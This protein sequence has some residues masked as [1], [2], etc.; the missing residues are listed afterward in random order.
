M[1]LAFDAA[2]DPDGELGGYL[3]QR[4]RRLALHDRRTCCAPTA[5]GGLAPR[6]SSTA[7]RRWPTSS[8]S[9]SPCTPPARTT[10]PMWGPQVVL[11]DNP[12][13][14]EVIPAYLHSLSPVPVLIPEYE[15]VGSGLPAGLVRGRRELLGAR[16]D[17]P[18]RRA[19]AL[20]R[21][22]RQ[23]H[24]ASTRSAGSRPTSPPAAPSCSISDRVADAED[25][26]SM[27]SCYFLLFDPDA[28]APA[29]PRAD[30]PLVHFAPGHRPPPRAHELGR[31]RHLVHLRPRLEHR[32]TTSTR[33]GNEF[34]F[35]R[36]G[37]WLTKERTGVRLQ[38]RLP[39]TTTTRSPWRTIR[40]T[41]NDP[42]DYRSHALAARL[43][44]DVR[45]RRRPDD[46][47]DER[48]PRLRL[49]P[50]R[51]DQPLQLERTRAR[52]T[53]STPAARSSGSRRT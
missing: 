34:E 17:R 42:D 5:R 10:R 9:C 25:H 53:S 29:D 36:N 40:R 30:L 43:A 14:D 15:Y 52:P 11:T 8:S 50:R 16:H 37:E 47:G 46:P 27:R 35:Y 2:D 31:G 39:P 22:H 26:A 7:R 20:R 3:E 28:P 13:W 48:R 51:R 6:G 45:R 1:A 24:A 23:H 49:R 19:R 44:M 4:D 33:D 21:T 38:H 41:H 12:F 18:A 32:S